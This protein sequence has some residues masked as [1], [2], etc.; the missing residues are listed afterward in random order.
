MADDAN[1]VGVPVFATEEEAL[2]YQVEQEKMFAL[3]QTLT[4]EERAIFFSMTL[5]EDRELFLTSIA[6]GDF[7]E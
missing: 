4:P 7:S 1:G 5:P 6:A 3:V 2:A